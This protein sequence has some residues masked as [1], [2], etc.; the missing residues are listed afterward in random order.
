MY[1]AERDFYHSKQISDAKS[2]LP[3]ATV[4]GAAKL[5]GKIASARRQQT[6][7]FGKKPFV[8]LKGLKIKRANSVI[9]DIV[10]DPKPVQKGLIDYWKPI[11]TAK[12]QRKPDLKKL[13]GIF[14][15]QMGH[16]FSFDS[17]GLPEESDY[18]A[19]ILTQTH[20]SPGPDGI[21]FA[22]YKAIAS[23]SASAMKNLAGAFASPPPSPPPPLSLLS[24][25]SLPVFPDKSHARLVV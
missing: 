5:K 10:T 17:I 4:A 3:K 18:G 7:L 16:T 13:L 2:L 25:L 6:T 23:T 9:E 1:R 20:S 12:P 19:N 11:Y 21:P 22:A 14:S 8:N 24:P 15:R